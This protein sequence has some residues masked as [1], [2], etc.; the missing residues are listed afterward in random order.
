MLDQ[1]P[2]EALAGVVGVDAHLLDVGGAVDE[3]EEEVAHRRVVGV[4]R[5]EGP[6]AVGVRGQLLD[7]AR[8]VV[9]EQVHVELQECLPCG[10]LDLDQQGEVVGAGGP[11]RHW[12]SLVHWDQETIPRSGWAGSSS[13]ARYSSRW[14]SGSRR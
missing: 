2:A 6:A 11:D 13:I 14:P 3:V 12:H 9:G 4:D 8:V 7:R 10:A 1:R 5:D